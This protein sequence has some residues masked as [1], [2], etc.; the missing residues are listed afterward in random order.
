VGGVSVEP[1]R[2]HWLHRGPDA[3][4]HAGKAEQGEQRAQQ[5]RERAE[6]NG[7]GRERERVEQSKTEEGERAEKSREREQS[8]ARRE[9]AEQGERAEQSKEREQRRTEQGERAEQSRGG[10]AEL[11]DREPSRERETSQAVAAVA[12]GFR[13]LVNWIPTRC[14]STG[15]SSCWT[16]RVPK[17]RNLPSTSRLTM[18]PPREVGSG[19]A[20]M[21]R[22]G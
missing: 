10:R 15:R 11:E 21:D 2:V 18:V 8:K 7:A 14:S 4:H 13:D 12:V 9:R 1:E 3:S 17:A 6:Q 19:T 5:S 20:L 22:R 16:C